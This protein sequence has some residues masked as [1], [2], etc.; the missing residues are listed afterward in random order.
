MI[1]S[2]YLIIVDNLIID[3]L[4]GVSNSSSGITIASESDDDEFSSDNEEQ[5]AQPTTITRQQPYKP[6]P[7]I[8]ILTC[9]N[10]NYLS[11]PYYSKF[12]LSSK[13]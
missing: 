10:Y 3:Q 5:T 4:G 12:S 2:W 6:T 9:I 13:E 8:I 7:V 1:I 11:L